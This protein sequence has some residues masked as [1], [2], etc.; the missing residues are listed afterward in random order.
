MEAKLEHD[1]KNNSYAYKATIVKSTLGALPARLRIDF[2]YQ[3]FSKLYEKELKAF[4]PKPALAQQALPL[5]KAATVNPMQKP[6]DVGPKI[7]Q[8]T[9]D[10]LKFL[11]AQCHISQDIINKWFSKAGIAQ[12]EE[13]TEEQAI[14]IIEKL[15]ANNIDAKQAWIDFVKVREDYNQEQAEGVAING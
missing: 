14:L 13:F 11:V 8:E 4:T 1:P 5:Q 9:K 3:T 15:E 12:W 2:N 6:V 7:K 10:H